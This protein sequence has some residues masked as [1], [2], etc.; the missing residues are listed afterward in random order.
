[1]KFGILTILCLIA[2]NA[3][4]IS[5]SAKVKHLF[6]YVSSQAAYCRINNAT[7]SVEKL[8]TLVQTDFEKSTEWQLIKAL[9]QICD[10]KFNTGVRDLKQ[11]KSNSHSNYI[12]AL[13]SFHLG[14]S[15][16]KYLR[17]DSCITYFEQAISIAK[18]INDSN[19]IGLSN[20]NLGRFY[21]DSKNYKSAIIEQQELLI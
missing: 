21:E 19:I 13:A 10:K 15:Y 1:M 6:D 9:N 17:S 14:R 16:R 4:G 18:S 5:D 8:K 2:I 11:I 20:Y 3:F 7:D 12:K